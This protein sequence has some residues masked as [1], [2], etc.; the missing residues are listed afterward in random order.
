MLLAM[1]EPAHQQTE[2]DEAVESNH[3]NGKD[4]VA[5]ER[6]IIL[7]MQH[8]RGNHRHFDGNCR[9]SKD[10]GPVRLAKFNG[11]AVGVPDDTN[12]RPKNNDEKPQENAHQQKRMR[13]VFHEP[14]SGSEENR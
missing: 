7:T 10:Q 11:E 4:R 8:R 6:R 5:P 12:R 9:K 13:G 14:V 1:A 2:P 3:D